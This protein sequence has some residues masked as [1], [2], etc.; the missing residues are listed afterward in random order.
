MDDFENMIDVWIQ[1]YQNPQQ[2]GDESA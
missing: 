2:A 1:E